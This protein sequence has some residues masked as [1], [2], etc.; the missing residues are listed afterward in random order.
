MGSRNPL[1]MGSSSSNLKS[2]ASSH[3]KTMPSSHRTINS[4]LKTWHPSMETKAI[5]RASI[6]LLR[7]ISPHLNTLLLPL[8]SSHPEL[9]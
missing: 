2:M 3:L 8:A 4:F 7:V 1:L 6:H 5:L 9:S